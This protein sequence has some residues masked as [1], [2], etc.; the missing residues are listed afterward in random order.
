MIGS[1]SNDFEDLFN[2]FEDNKSEIHET[3]CA[4]VEEKQ[5]NAFANN[6]TC[7]A[8]CRKNYLDSKSLCIAR[9]LIKE[10]KSSI[11]NKPIWTMIPQISFSLVDIEEKEFDIKIQRLIASIGIFSLNIIHHRC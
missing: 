6:L 1:L 5:W 4:E 2:N 3:I 9:S 7:T 10:I 11:A 8:W